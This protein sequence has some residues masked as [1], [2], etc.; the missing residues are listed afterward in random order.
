MLGTTILHLSALP[1]PLLRQVYVEA[2]E[3]GR[4]EALNARLGVLWIVS[5]AILKAFWSSGLPVVASR[6]PLQRPGSLL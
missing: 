5:E 1:V 4:P 6:Q 2:P 3:Q